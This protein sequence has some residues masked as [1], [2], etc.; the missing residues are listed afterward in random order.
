MSSTVIQPTTH[1]EPL[2]STSSELDNELDSDLDEELF[3]ELDSDSDAEMPDEDSDDADVD[4]GQHEFT[5]RHV[6]PTMGVLVQYNS[7]CIDKN[8]E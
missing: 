3:D 8:D 1:H 6:S 5:F 7:S 2:A 4:E